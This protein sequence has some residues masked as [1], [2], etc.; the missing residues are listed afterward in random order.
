[1]YHILNGICRRRKRRS[2]R[3]VD[4]KTLYRPFSNPSEEMKKV[5]KKKKMSEYF[6]YRYRVVDCSHI[7]CLHKYCLR[8]PG[9]Q[10]AYIYL[11]LIIDSIRLDILILIIPCLFT[12]MGY[13]VILVRIL[14]YYVCY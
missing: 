2:I 14:V 10:Y 1:M 8:L 12:L 4:Q 9:V 11:A 7:T 5:K 13:D 3:R 6:F